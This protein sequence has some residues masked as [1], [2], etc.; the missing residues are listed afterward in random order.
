MS[1]NMQKTIPWLEDIEKQ[2]NEHFT[3][4]NKNAPIL[5]RFVKRS[6]KKMHPY[7]MLD[8][9]TD[10]GEVVD[11]AISE[12]AIA[13]VEFV[14]AVSSKRTGKLVIIDRKNGKTIKEHRFGEE[15][16]MGGI[17][18]ANDG[19]VIVSSVYGS[20]YCYK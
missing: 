10:R 6:A 15:P 4:K 14:G 5:F 2:A 8:W 1:W 16:T 20:V 7:P 19:S 3:K 12:N 17:A 18:I 11:I 13:V 9:N